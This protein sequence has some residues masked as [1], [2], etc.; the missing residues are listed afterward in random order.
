MGQVLA[1]KSELREHR[2]QTIER[3]KKEL[4]ELMDAQTALDNVEE[5]IV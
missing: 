4:Q 1:R 2:D 3:H 5:A